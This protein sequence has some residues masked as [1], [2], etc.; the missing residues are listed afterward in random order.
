[1]IAWVIE[2]VIRRICSVA[3]DSQGDYAMRIPGDSRRWAFQMH[4]ASDLLNDDIPAWPEVSHPGGRIGQR[5]D[6]FSENMSGLPGNRQPRRT[7]VC[8]L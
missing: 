1:V 5:A 6:E 3:Q 4:V 2:S 8:V 7:A